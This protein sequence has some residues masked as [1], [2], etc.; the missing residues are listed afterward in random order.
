VSVSAT[1]DLK[2]PTTLYTQT[3]MALDSC[4]P[5]CTVCSYK[6]SG[7]GFWFIPDLGF[8][9]SFFFFGRG[10]VL[11]HVWLYKSQDS[12]ALGGPCVIEE[13]IQIHEWCLLFSIRERKYNMGIL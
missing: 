2:D 4:E 7:R 13:D 5:I 11:M 1:Q 3:P 10:S 8:L 12:Y 9:V 6:R